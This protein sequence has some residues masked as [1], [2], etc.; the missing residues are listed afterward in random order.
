M[1]AYD[2]CTN[3]EK[4]LADVVAIYG[5]GRELFKPPTTTKCTIDTK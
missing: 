4:N 1:D 5:R 3:L 2:S